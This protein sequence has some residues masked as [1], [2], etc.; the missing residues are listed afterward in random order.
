MVPAGAGGSFAGAGICKNGNSEDGHAG[1]S[2][3]RSQRWEGLKIFA[4]WRRKFSGCAVGRESRR[5]LSVGGDIDP[6]GTIPGNRKAGAARSDL[7]VPVAVCIFCDI[8]PGT[9]SGAGNN[10]GDSARR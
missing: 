5:N 9:D 6:A 7:P 2:G 8:L 1:T 10:A 4:E 3:A